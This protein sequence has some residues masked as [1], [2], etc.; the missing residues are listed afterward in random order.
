MIFKKG[1]G[2]FRFFANRD[3]SQFDSESGMGGSNLFKR[4]G[5]VNPSLI[6]FF[7]KKIP[8]LFLKT[9]NWIK[10]V[11]LKILFSVNDFGGTRT[12]TV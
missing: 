10:Y 3:G 11:C 7:G 2:E 4:N 1:K 12:T 9:V 8:K 5:R 6:S